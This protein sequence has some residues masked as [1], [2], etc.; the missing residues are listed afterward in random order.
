MFPN[1]L[2]IIS[3]V[4]SFFFT[5][6]CLF[7]VTLL[8]LGVPEH[9]ALASRP[10]THSLI[11]LF[12]SLMAFPFPFELGIVTQLMLFNHLLRGWCSVCVGVGGV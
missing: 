10:L 5:F 8:C 3:P 11:R 1:R 2:F 4:S 9:S 6:Y 12:L 7:S